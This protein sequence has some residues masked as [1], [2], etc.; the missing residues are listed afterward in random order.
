MGT[1]LKQM[2][3]ALSAFFTMIEVMGHAGTK[4]AKSLDHLGGWCEDT[5]GA[6]A[7]TAREERKQAMAVLLATTTRS[8]ATNGIDTPALPAPAATTTA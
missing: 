6:F 5:A 1:M 8:L 7:D 2:W 3:V 4:V